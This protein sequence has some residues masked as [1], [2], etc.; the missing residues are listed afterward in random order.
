MNRHFI[1]RVLAVM[2]VFVLCACNAENEYSRDYQCHFIFYP[3]HHPQ[4]VLYG[5]LQNPGVFARVSVQKQQGINHVIVVPNTG[6][7]SENIA[8]TTEI[9]NN[10]ITYLMGANNAIIIGCD[11]NMQPVAFDGQCRNC[12]ENYSTTNYPLSWSDNGRTVTCAKCHRV[13]NL[14]ANGTCSDGKPLYKYRAF[15]STGYDGTE[16]VNAMN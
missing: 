2:A 3:Q 14:N 10:R 13:Y 1:Q 16:T 11:T 15:M 12:L 9:E 8:L 4:S 5:I 7:K 6:A